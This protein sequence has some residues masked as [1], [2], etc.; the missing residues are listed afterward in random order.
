[1]SIEAFFQMIEAVAVVVALVFAMVQVR[2]HERRQIR[3][4]ALEMLHAFQTPDFAKALSLVYGMPDGLSKKEVE[5]R[6]GDDMHLVYAMTTTW[7]SIG[8]LVYRGE[9]SLD[10]LDD[11]FSG[12]I[13]ISWRKLR[14]YFEDEREEQGRQT[15]SEWFQWLAERFG[16][17]ESIEAPVPAHI[18]HRDWMP[19]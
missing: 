18:A 17:R 14:P 7:E 19:A 11:F 4:S 9:I 1:M 12:P 6:F 16:N 5:E 15:I 10:L 2:Q 13:T 3:E 8:V